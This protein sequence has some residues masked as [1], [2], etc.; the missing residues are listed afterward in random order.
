MYIY[1]YIKKFSLPYKSFINVMKYLIREKKVVE[2]FRRG[3]I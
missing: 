1:I 2:N 3:K